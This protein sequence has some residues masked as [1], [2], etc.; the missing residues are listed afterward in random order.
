MKRSAAA[1]RP[2]PKR[3]KLASK[4]GEAKYNKL[5]ASSEVTKGWNARGER[6]WKE[7][8]ADMLGMT[9]GGVS[10]ADLTFSNKALSDLPSLLRKGRKA[11]QKR[12]ERVSK[13]PPKQFFGN[14]LELGA[15]IGRVTQ[16]ALR[17]HCRQVHLVEFM[18][19]YL[20]KAKKTLPRKGC[21]LYF[22]CSSAQKC[23]IAVNRHDLIWCQWLLMYLVDTEAVDLLKRASKGL[24]KNGGVLVVKENVMKAL[25]SSNKY[26]E[27]EDDETWKP[28]SGKAPMNIVRTRK[29]FEH[30]FKQAGLRIRGSRRQVGVVG[31]FEDM[32]LW[33]LEPSK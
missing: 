7:Q 30:L 12:S 10:R 25:K 1:S 22:H 32:H 28:G 18:K 9:G 11:S 5:W 2:A 13:T 21:R 14:C 29:H 33:I 6:Y 24:T 17:H 8:P 16:G 3:R 27:N 20:D 4:A 19:K 26:F 31:V 15:G 23:K